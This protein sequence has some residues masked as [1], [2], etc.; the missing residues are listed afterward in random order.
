MT[1]ILAINGSYRDDGIT[2]QAVTAIITTLRE[3]GAEVEE[4]RLR[5]TPIEFCLNCRECTQSPG[6]APGHCVQADA[7]HTLV[8]KIET[9]DGYI[10]ASPTN[11]GSV[12]ALFKRFMERLVVYGYWPWGAP[13]PQ[14]RKA[15]LAKKPALLVSSSAAPALMGRWLFGTRSQLKQTATTIGAKAVGTLF[16]GLAAGE[17]H[18]VLPERERQRAVKLAQRLLRP[19]AGSP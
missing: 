3:A 11:F 8:E 6:E 10:L 14:F 5:D 16:I 7:M 12:T 13:F 1:R 2:D 9:A 18:P 15:G 17:P 4:I 19:P